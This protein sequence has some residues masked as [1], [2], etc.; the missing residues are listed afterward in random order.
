MSKKETLEEYKVNGERGTGITS[1]A[2]ET[3]KGQKLGRMGLVI[4][5]AFVGIGFLYTSWNSDSGEAQKDETRTA[6]IAAAVP[7]TPVA[8]PRVQEEKLVEQPVVQEIIPPLPVEEPNEMLESSMR[9]PV[10]AF[11]ANINRNNQTSDEEF[12]Q[13]NFSMDLPEGFGL[14]N[15]QQDRLRDK[16]QPT[17]IE[18]VSASV[19][20]NLH[21]VVPQGTQIP[22]TLQ[23]AVSSDQP[24]LVSCIIQRD[25]LGASGQVVLMEK[26]TS[27]VGEYNGDLRQGQK[28]I[29][30]LWNRARTPHG[31]IVNLASP[32]TDGLGRTGFDGKVDNHFWQRFGGAILMSIVSD[33]SNYGLPN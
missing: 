31:V 2:Q 21:M 3:N 22:C 26:G 14:G 5:I 25:V 11:S 4:T 32:A 9:A 18:G 13:T 17:P 8:A 23:T 12:T 19:L 29:F 33:A 20:P 15:Q 7:F 30:V 24:G 6:S 10:I 28:R 16:L 27:I 1:V